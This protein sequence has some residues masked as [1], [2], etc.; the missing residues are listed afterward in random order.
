M[1][2]EASP[3]GVYFRMNKGHDMSRSAMLL[4]L[5]SGIVFSAAAAQNDAQVT[6]VAE[7]D[8]GRISLQDLKEAS[9]E[10]LA[11][12][13][14]QVYQLKHDK[15]EQMIDDRLLEREAQHRNVP[16]QTLIDTEITAKAAEVTSQEI[17]SV[18]ELN[19]NQLKKPEAEV[20]EQLRS[21]LREQKIG[22]RRR[23]FARSL[24]ATAKVAIYLDAPLPFRAHVRA[25]GPSRSAPDASVTIVDVEDVQCPFC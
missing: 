18:Y 12:L 15:L 19:M 5:T 9:G 10:P 17:H 25:D 16:L 23:E 4:V 20:A 13:E 11:R 21:L 22:T 7:V 2:R 6:T 24:Q 3:P 1:C 8:G 14:E